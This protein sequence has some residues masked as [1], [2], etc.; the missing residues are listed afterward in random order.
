MVTDNHY[1]WDFIGL[2]T[3]DKPTPETSCKVVDGSTFYCSDNSKLYVFY[4]G[5]WYERKPL[6]GGGGSSVI[7]LTSADYNYPTDNP[8]SVALWELEPGLYTKGTGVTTRTSTSNQDGLAGDIFLVGKADNN[9][10][11]GITIFKKS[12]QT[13]YSTDK[14]S[15]ASVN[16]GKDVFYNDMIEQ[17]TGTAATTVMSQNATT[18]MVFDDPSA[19]TTIKIGAAAAYKINLGSGAYTYSYGGIAIGPSSNAPE[20]GS[21]ALGFGANASKKGAVAIGPFASATTVGQ[22]DFGASNSGQT[23]YGYNS[24]Q[25]RLLTGLYDPQSDHDAA[26]KGYVDPTT[27]SSAPTSATVGRLGQIFI[28]TTNADAYMCVAVD[29]VTPSYT[30]KKINA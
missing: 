20:N 21:V 15:G 2:S 28:D 13:Q 4:D 7:E 3:D 26:T 6:G 1:R 9:D 12:S 10:R 5:T 29:T 24:S 19:Q 8:T 17:S 23:S 27:D 25:Y 22:V 30:W 18:S 14:T 11:V 16:N